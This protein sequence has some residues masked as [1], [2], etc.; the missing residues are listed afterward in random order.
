MQHHDVFSNFKPFRGEMPAHTAIDFL[1]ANTRREF[2]AGLPTHPTPVLA[3][4]AYPGVSEEYLEWIDLLESVVAARDSYTMI[5]LGAG[6]GR[7][8]VRAAFALKQYNDKI[9]YR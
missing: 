4:M 6:F 7:W 1:G 2:I 5:D 9:P 3:E 8:S